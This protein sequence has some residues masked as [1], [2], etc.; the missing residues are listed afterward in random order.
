MEKRRKGIITY[1]HLGADD[2]KYFVDF[3]GFQEG[4]GSPI[5]TKEEINPEI[6]RLIR[7]HSNKYKL[8]IKKE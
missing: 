3:W 7:M 1:G 8:E 4:S 5:K 2:F 6:K